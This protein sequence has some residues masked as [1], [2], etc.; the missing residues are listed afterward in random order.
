MPPVKREEE[1]VW[2][3]Q[4]YLAFLQSDMIGA[5]IALSGMKTVSM[6]NGGALIAILAAYPSLKTDPAFM[7][8]FSDASVKFLIGL[9][10]AITAFIISYIYQGLSTKMI[11]IELNGGLS[12]GNKTQHSGLKKSLQAAWWI[13]F[14]VL[15]AAFAMFVWGS[16]ILTDGL[17]E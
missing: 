10:I 7:A 3:N 2:W 9:S 11:H 4:T 5:N 12:A 13:A 15:C 1:M 17:A 14:L 6:S 16:W 8:V